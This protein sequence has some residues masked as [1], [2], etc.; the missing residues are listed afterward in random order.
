MGEGGGVSTPSASSSNGTQ[1]WSAFL[2][3]GVLNIY[4]ALHSTGRYARSRARENTYTRLL[5]CM[6]A[7]GSLVGCTVSLGGGRS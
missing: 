5:I 4:D 2:L 3:T 6:D 7:R 1:P